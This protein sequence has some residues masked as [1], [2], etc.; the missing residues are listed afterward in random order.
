MR[1]DL[2]TASAKVV[3]ASRSIALNALRIARV[4]VVAGTCRTRV[5]E[6]VDLISVPKSRSQPETRGRSRRQS[7]HAVLD[8]RITSKARCFGSRFTSCGCTHPSRKLGDGLGTSCFTRLKQHP[9]NFAP[10]MVE[11]FRES[12]WSGPGS[13]A[14]HHI[15]QGALKVK[16]GHR[17]VG[18]VIN[19]WVIP[20]GPREWARALIQW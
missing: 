3:T 8:N 17:P 20:Y 16:V 13:C 10:R 18:H 14:G 15:S 4:C 12:N 11:G 19:R 6:S 2:T 5:G 7:G 1:H 9:R